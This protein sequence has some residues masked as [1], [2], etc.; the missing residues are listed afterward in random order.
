M[1]TDGQADMTKLKLRVVQIFIASMQKRGEQ[2][3][4]ITPLIVPN[5]VTAGDSSCFSKYR[6]EF[7]E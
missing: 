3:C 6:F 1:R 2:N 4:G 5:Y 7:D